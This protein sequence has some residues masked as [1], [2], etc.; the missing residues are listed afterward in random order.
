M[1][2]IIGLAGFAGSGKDTF[3]AGLG[4]RFQRVAFADPLKQALLA[5]DPWVRSAG[6]P[7]SELV[8]PDPLAG[9][10]RAKRIHPEVRSL[11]QRMGTD[12]VRGHVDP[13]AWI[14]AAARQVQAL[15]DT[16]ADVVLTDVRFPDEAAAVIAWGGTVIEVVRPGTGPAGDHASEQV[17]PRPLVGMTV[18]NDGSLDQL[19]SIARHLPDDVGALDAAG[20]QARPRIV[21]DAPATPSFVARVSEEMMRQ[22]VLPEDSPSGEPLLRRALSASGLEPSMLR[23]QDREHLLANASGI[24]RAT[25]S[26]SSS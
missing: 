21:P 7:L 3:A 25:C 26:G 15:L 13:E 9:L 2:C 10:E 6:A 4:A 22:A 5:L 8:G 1:T 16:G 11:L 17:L 23:R 18:V 24:V 19:L 14:A 20:G 12:A